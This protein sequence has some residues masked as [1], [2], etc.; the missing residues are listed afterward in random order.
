M[1]NGYIKI[2]AFIIEETHLSGNHL[3]VYCIIREFTVSKKGIFNNTYSYFTNWLSITRQQVDKILNDLI[4]LGLIVK[5]KESNSRR[6]QLYTVK[7]NDEFIEYNQKL[8]YEYSGLNLDS[9][10]DKRYVLI[11]PDMVNLYHLKSYELILF[12]LIDGYNKNNLTVHQDNLNY[13]RSFLTV[14]K[15]TFNATLNR[16]IEKQ[17]IIKRSDGIGSYIYISKRYVNNFD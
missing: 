1:V 17:L 10:N 9:L 16:L 2:K 13:L 8:R 7:R 5:K 12:A 11:D 15:Q 4:G 3:L 6:V 14:H